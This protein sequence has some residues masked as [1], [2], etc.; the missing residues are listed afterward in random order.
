MTPRNVLFEEDNWR[1]VK[2][3]YQYTN[4]FLLEHRCSTGLAFLTYKTSTI[5]HACNT[6][7]PES[8]QV[9]YTLLSMK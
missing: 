8:I 6:K 9:L 7:P 3:P 2:T 1:I 5:C 4:D